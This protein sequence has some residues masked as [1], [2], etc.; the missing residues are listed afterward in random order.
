MGQCLE[1][2][3]LKNKVTAPLHKYTFKFAKVVDVYDGDTITVIAKHRGEY[4]TFKIRMKGINAPE[5][6]RQPRETEEE[7]R[8]R[9]LSAELARNYLKDRI[10]GKVVKIEHYGTEKYGRILARIHYNG[11]N[12]CEEMVQLGHAE[13]YME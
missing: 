11:S 13:R 3:A 4:N 12:V 7:G 10:F 5:I 8:R 6:R 9:Q 2:Q 1:K